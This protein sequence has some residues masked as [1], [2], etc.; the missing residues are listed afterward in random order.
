MNSILRVRLAQAGYGHYDH[1]EPVV[2]LLSNH[3]IDPA[4]SLGPR[5]RTATFRMS[6][7]V[8]C[9]ALRVA[10]CVLRAA[11]CALRVVWFQP[12]DRPRRPPKGLAPCAVVPPEHSLWTALNANAEDE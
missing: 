12:L 3:S 5:T 7:L 11:C 2:G 9:C 6:A 10:R 1:I 4:Y 8:P